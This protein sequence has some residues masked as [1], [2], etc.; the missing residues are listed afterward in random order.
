MAPGNSRL[1]A[2]ARH[3]HARSRRDRAMVRGCLDYVPSDVV[4]FVPTPQEALPGRPRGSLAIQT[5]DGPRRVRERE[6]QASAVSQNDRRPRATAADPTRQVPGRSLAAKGLP[7]QT[8]PPTT[9]EPSA[10]PKFF[11][12]TRAS[13]SS[14]ARRRSQ[15]RPRSAAA[16]LTPQAPSARTWPRQAPPARTRPRDLKID[17]LGCEQTQERAPPLH[18]PAR[19]R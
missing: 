4:A 10:V 13:V 14:P 8:R 6:N 9:D 11:C 2:E 16:A 7:D 1:T 5:R 18:T 12:W 3:G 19:S 15:G 17:D